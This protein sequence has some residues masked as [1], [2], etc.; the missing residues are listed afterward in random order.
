MLTMLAEK[1][2]PKA[3]KPDQV[4]YCPTMDLVAVATIDEQV[5]V[6]RLNGQR[7]FG[8]ANKKPSCKI[9]QLRWKPNG[10]LHIHD[11]RA[12]SLSLAPRPTTRRCFK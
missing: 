7:V 5:Q 4:A 6:F 12:N 1:I 3:L 11:L 2:A 10:Q 9:T 8:V